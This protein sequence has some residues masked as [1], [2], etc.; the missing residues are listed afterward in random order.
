MYV[1]IFMNQ[2]VCLAIQA[3]QPLTYTFNIAQ[4]RTMNCLDY[5]IASFLANCYK[6]QVAVEESAIALV[7][8]IYGDS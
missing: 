6:V 3:L 8:V 5:T 7:T 4:N 2:M 1:S